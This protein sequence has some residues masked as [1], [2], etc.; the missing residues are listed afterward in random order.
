MPFHKCKNM[1][2]KQRIEYLLL[3]LNTYIITFIMIFKNN[4]NCFFLGFLC[5]NFESAFSSVAVLTTPKNSHL[6]EGSPKRFRCDLCPYSTNIKCNIK[7]HYLVHSGERPHKCKVCNQ[8]FTQL[9]ALKHHMFIHTG[10]KPY[11]C[12]VCHVSFRQPGPLKLHMTKHL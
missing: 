4:S 12:N 6:S 10:E 9:N 5:D 7:T 3:L 8:G 1:H 2:I 11:L